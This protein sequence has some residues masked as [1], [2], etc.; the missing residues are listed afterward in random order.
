MVRKVLMTSLLIATFSTSDAQIKTK[1]SLPEQEIIANEKSV[2]ELSASGKLEAYSKRLSDDVLAVYSTG[3]ANKT[4]VLDALRAMTDVHYSMDDVKVVKVS[5]QAA[6]IVYKLAQ[7]WKEGGKTLTREYYVSSL[8]TNDNGKWL[9][10]FWQETDREADTAHGDSA[11]D[12]AFF[13]AIEKEDWEALKH[14]DKVA[15]SRLLADDFTGLYDTGFSTKSEWIKQM[16]DQYTI[17][18]Y[19]IEDAELLRPSP[20]TALLLYNSR[21]KGTGAWADY[22]SHTSRISDLMVQRDGRWFDLFSQD[23]QA[24]PQTNSSEVSGSALASTAIGSSAVQHRTT[25]TERNPKDEILRLVR[26]EWEAIKK[27]DRAALGALQE[28]DYFDFGSDGWVDRETGLNTGWMGND[29]TLITFKFEDARVTLLD[30]HTALMTYR[31][32]YQ[33]IDRGKPE[34]GS[35]FYSDVFQKQNGEWHIVFT[36]DSNLKC[37]GM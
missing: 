1:D 11:G 30:E 24:L 16:D 3:Y 12:L 2:L 9:N 35:A 20:T 28:K 27:K 23:T 21:C 34:N 17:D 31:G 18:D 5:N 7:D 19:T 25:Q 26:M 14:K 29:G 32:T 4:D 36:Q 22:C 37:A 33:A 13:V 15:A 6:V 10:R 8:W